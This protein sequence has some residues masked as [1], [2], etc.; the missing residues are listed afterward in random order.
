V[1]GCF[2]RKCLFGTGRCSMMSM[3]GATQCQNSPS[4]PNSCL[5]VWEGRTGDLE[6]QRTGLSSSSPA[7][8]G[9]QVR[10]DPSCPTPAPGK[11]CL[12]TL[13][14]LIKHFFTQELPC[15]AHGRAEPDAGLHETQ[16]W[17]A[18]GSEQAAAVPAWSMGRRPLLSAS[19][20]PNRSDGRNLG[21]C[22]NPV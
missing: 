18:S 9:G 5:C 12:A 21:L 1:L 22:S 14:T 19:T 2:S 17:A 15:I 6:P 4:S 10:A 13:P 16:H 7:F 8:V 20:C 3:A 11:A